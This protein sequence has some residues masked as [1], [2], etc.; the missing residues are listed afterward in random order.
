MRKKLS[1]PGLVL[2]LASTLADACA[3]ASMGPV[4]SDDFGSFNTGKI[5]LTEEGGIAALSMRRV[6][7]HDDRFYLYTQSRL[8]G[9]S[10][11]PASDSASG[12][13]SAAATDSLFGAVLA[14]RPNSLK[15]DY[16]TTRNAADM[17]TYT[18]RITFNNATK[19]IRADDGTMPPEMRRILS[20]VHATISAARK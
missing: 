1:G 9:S 18:L 4:S 13:L 19:T 12:T 14:E 11:Q 6:V 17:M 7:R 20:A 10:C 2:F 8:C 5:E 15:D 16:G 3:T